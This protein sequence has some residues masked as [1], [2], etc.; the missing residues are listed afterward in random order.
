MKRKL[1]KIILIGVLAA[2]LVLFTAAGT[3]G[4]E[5]RIYVRTNASGQWEYDLADASCAI[6][7]ISPNRASRALRAIFCSRGVYPCLRNQ[8]RGCIL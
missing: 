8:L 7:G 1:S 4:E 6:T 2:L 3:A 5:E